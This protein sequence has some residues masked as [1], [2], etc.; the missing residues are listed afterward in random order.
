ML[1]QSHA[2]W[3]EMPCWSVGAINL[4]GLDSK[5]GSLGAVS[6]RDIEASSQPLNAAELGSIQKYIGRWDSTQVLALVWGSL[7]NTVSP[8]WSQV[9]EILKIFNKGA[10]KHFAGHKRV[11]KHIK[12]VLMMWPKVNERTSYTCQVF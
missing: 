1:N 7:L 3:K 9:I 6:S 5:L 8:D 4:P 10:P 11:T 12:T 2:I